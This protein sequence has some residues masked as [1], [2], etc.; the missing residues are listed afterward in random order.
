MNKEHTFDNFVA[1]FNRYYKYRTP[2]IQKSGIEFSKEN[3]L[4]L[5]E[6]FKHIGIQVT[7]G[8]DSFTTEG[9]LVCEVQYLEDLNALVFR[10]Q[11]IDQETWER[12]IDFFCIGLSL[13]SVYQFWV[14]A[15][16]GS[17]YLWDCPIEKT[18]LL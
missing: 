13:F 17:K 1:T 4:T 10:V 14:Q 3:F 12:F 2:Y 5:T 7:V 11:K 16:D 9:E 15:N 18:F 6:Y 8:K